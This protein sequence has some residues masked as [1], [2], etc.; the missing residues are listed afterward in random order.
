MADIEQ[1]VTQIRQATDFQTNKRILRERRI[2]DL[3][4]PYQNGMFLLSPALLAFVSTWPTEWLYLEDT[5]GNPVEVEKQIFL[6]KA[7]Q[8][9]SQVMNSWHQELEELKKQRRV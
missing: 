8:H 3:H 7:Q 9:Y 4:F 6:V 5:Y 2:S 1:I